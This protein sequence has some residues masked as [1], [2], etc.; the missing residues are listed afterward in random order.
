MFEAA[1][2]DSAPVEEIVW[3]M[4]EFVSVISGRL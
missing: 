2:S 1:I 4:A 3:R